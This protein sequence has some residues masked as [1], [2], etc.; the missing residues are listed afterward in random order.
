[1]RLHS[2]RGQER[3][4]DVSAEIGGRDL[5]NGTAELTD[6]GAHRRRDDHFIHTTPQIPSFDAGRPRALQRLA[7]TFAIRT[8]R[9]HQRAAR[10]R[11]QI[12]SEEE[13]PSAAW[14]DGPAIV[15]KSAT[16]SRIG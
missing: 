14:S 15:P 7:I 3:L 13:L 2:R 4:E 12:P 6:R 1:M 11:P 16:T 9:G 5:G 10:T 8:P